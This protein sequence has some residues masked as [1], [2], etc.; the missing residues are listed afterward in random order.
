MIY[1]YPDFSFT[2][3]VI[4]GIKTGLHAAQHLGVRHHGVVRGIH[5]PVFDQRTQQQVVAFRTD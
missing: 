5:K 2:P 1:H 3:D 4:Q